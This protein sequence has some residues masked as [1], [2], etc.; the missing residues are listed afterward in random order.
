MNYLIMLTLLTTPFMQAMNLKYS[1]PFK[2]SL[3]E[4]EKYVNS[5]EHVEL[6]EV[7]HALYSRNFEIAKILLRK[8]AQDSLNPAEIF[9]T[10][11]ALYF[12]EK[13]KKGEIIWSYATNQ[14]V[15]PTDATT[16]EHEEIPLRKSKSALEQL[17]GPLCIPLHDA[18][19]TPECVAESAPDFIYW[20]IE[21]QK[22]DPNIVEPFYHKTA[23]HWAL[24]FGSPTVVKA[25][26]RYNVLS[27]LM[28]VDCENKTPL[29]HIRDNPRM[30]ELVD[31][32][33]RQHGVRL[34]KGF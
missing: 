26:L 33:L 5:V 23:L 19:A 7:K 12:K 3:A 22:V 1:I 25:L 18:A 27:S 15:I 9:P 30:Q 29:H 10:P 20:L 28:I 8:R 11:S 4:A 2:G 14:Y 6:N 13:V 16:V 34:D 21:K 31:N 32:C 24:S 17:G